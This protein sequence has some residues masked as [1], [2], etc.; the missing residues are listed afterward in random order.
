MPR[1]G[2][3]AVSA[4]ILSMLLVP[5]AHAAVQYEFARETLLPLEGP[6]KS[7]ARVS[8]DRVPLLDGE[9]GTLDVEQFDVW[10]PGADI[11]VFGADGEVLEQLKPPPVRYFRGEVKGHPGSLVFL[12]VGTHRVDGLVYAGDRKFAIGSRRL[13]RTGSRLVIEESSVLDDV[14]MDGEAFKC[15]VENTEVFSSSRPHAITN[16]FGDPVSL[17]APTGT[18]RSMIN[19][20]V[21]TDYEL[22]TR[23]GNSA[24]NV[25]TYIGDLVGKASTIYDRDLL[26]NIRISYLGVRSNSSDPFT[27]VPGTAGT[28]NGNAVTLTSAHAMYELGDYWHNTP[29]SAAPR[30]SV[31]L[32]SGKSQMAGI[33]W[34][35][36]LCVPD[37]LC[38][39]NCGSSDA[40]GHYAGAY[41]FCGG[42]DPPNDLSVPDPDANVNYGAPGSNYWPL[43]QLT[44]ELGHN[45]G[46]THTHCITVD[47]ATYGRS[48]VDQ[49]VTAGGC[50]SG[51][52]S[53]PAEKG[54]IM[55]YCH[56]VGP[57]YGLNTRFTFGQLGEA[58]EVV[59]TNMRASMAG[60]TPAISSITAPASLAPA[61]SGAASVTNAGLAYSWS[62][63][64]G[65]ITSATNVAAITFTALTDPLVLTVTATNTSGCSITDRKTVS[66]TGV[67]LS[68][69]AAIAA[70]ATSATSVGLT[71]SAV[72]GATGYEIR[73][74]AD[75]V[76]FAL[77]GTSVG[78]S[79]NDVGRPSNTAFLYKVAATAGATTGP[80]SSVDLATTVAFTDPA[81][82]SGD[83]IA[84]AHFTELLT[85]VNAVRSLAAQ[86]A[87]AFS[88]PAPAASADVLKAHIDELRAG[89]N[90]ARST[91]LLGAASYTDP[92][93]VAGTTPIKAAHITD[94]RAAV[95][96]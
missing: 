9:P 14:P 18:Q 63:T 4:F 92:T 72:A 66:V 49:C 53:V 52:T 62:I 78:P 54:T 51:P 47:P 57:S 44:H 87:I 29:P 31:V 13:G 45:V 89:L 6:L 76:N 21:D 30:S 22:Y 84:T 8:V 55:S 34:R 39:G 86:S 33:A 27:I 38:A 32:V 35:D 83:S 42:V 12:S 28:W 48:Y 17:A 70:S 41:A 43:L 74:S 19:L 61:A 91:L 5:V 65:T 46:S 1:S 73:R 60:R 24:A 58:S 68:A 25:T 95:N 23:S 71:W 96:Q 15:E 2:R 59:R 11:K 80:F 64:G 79:F 36:Q 81:L 26:T 20:A 94:L 3:A 50:Y 56:N 88:L 40:T 85:A 82:G 77:A 75:G 7:G 67:S 90:A 37:M 16:G 10:A 69:P 93:I